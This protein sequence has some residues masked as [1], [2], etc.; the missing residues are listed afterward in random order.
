MEKTGALCHADVWGLLVF[1][2]AA[3]LWRGPMRCEVLT[4][5]YSASNFK[6]NNNISV[7]ED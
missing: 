7:F 4:E 5:F 1:V 2:A 6:K 3:T